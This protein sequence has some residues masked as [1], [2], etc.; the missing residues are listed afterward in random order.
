MKNYYEILEVSEK[1]SYEVIEK[2]YKILAKK[3]HPDLQTSENTKWAEEKFKEIGE[4]YEILSNDISRQNYDIQLYEYKKSLNNSSETNNYETLIKHTQ[5][6]ENELKSIKEKQNHINSV[7][8]SANENQ[9]DNTTN[10][11]NQTIRKAY[12]DA[13]NDVYNSSYN[14]GIKIYSF[15]KKIKTMLKKFIKNILTLFL[16]ILAIIIIF[17][18]L[19]KIPFIKSYFINI[20]NDNYALQLLLKPIIKK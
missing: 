19:W 4:A 9:L 13:Y 16:T 14:N 20:Y 15:S 17:Y 2:A 11:F 18:I 3:Y 7:N 10:L 8:N 12:S 1:A 5:E 6:L